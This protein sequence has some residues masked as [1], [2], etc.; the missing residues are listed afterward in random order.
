MVLALYLTREMK[1]LNTKKL[2]DY[3]RATHVK[4]DPQEA[5]AALIDMRL[6]QFEEKFHRYLR[7]LPVP[8]TRP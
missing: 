4:T 7:D 5:F 6:D 2:D 8:R 3:C 1:I